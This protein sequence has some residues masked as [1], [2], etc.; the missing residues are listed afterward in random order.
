M[1]HKPIFDA[2]RS[3]AGRKF[4]RNEI[5]KLDRAIECAAGQIASCHPSP[6]SEIGP[7][8]IALIKSFEGCAR[9]RTDGLVEAYP[10]PGTGS[11]P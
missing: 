2:V 11:A 10:D 5:T 7:E 8:G 4:K 3:I 1:N 9:Q 6:T